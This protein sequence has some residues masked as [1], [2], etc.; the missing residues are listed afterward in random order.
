MTEKNK[1][2][3]IRSKNTSISSSFHLEADRSIRGMAIILS[4]IIGISDFSEEQIILNSHGGRILI[5]GRGLFICVYEGGS[6]EI[7]GRV[8]EIA[9]KYGKN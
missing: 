6:V 2:E 3:S 8:E 7:S 5:N 1:P 9:F 4:G